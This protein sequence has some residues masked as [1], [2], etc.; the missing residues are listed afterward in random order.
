MDQAVFDK[1]YK[2]LNSQREVQTNLLEEEKKDNE[3]SEDEEDIR[4][5]EKFLK[6]VIKHF[7]S[8]IA[9]RVSY[10]VNYFAE[11]S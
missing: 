5:F 1:E 6:G 8:E 7:N 11:I 3:G 9:A 4:V 10:V 2:R